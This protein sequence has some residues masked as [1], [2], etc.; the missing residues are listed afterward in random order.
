MRRRSRPLL[1]RSLVLLGLGFVVAAAVVLVLASP[2]G[3]PRPQLLPAPAAAEANGTVV[4]AVDGDTVVV[5]IGGATE[6]VRLIGVDTPETVDERKPVQCYGPEASARTAALLPAGTPV[7]LER[8]TEARDQYGR[9]LAYLFRASDGLFVNLSLVRDGF[10][11][12]LA[13]APNTTFVTQLR[14]AERSAKAAGVGLWGAC[15]GP[16]VPAAATSTTGP[17]AGVTSTTG[18]PSSPAPPP[19]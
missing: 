3:G 15:G 4:R 13:I 5:Q 16:G 14:D 19:R 9:L 2:E 6:S 1:S 10:G 12:V 11:T 7:R 17:P 18:P 8:D